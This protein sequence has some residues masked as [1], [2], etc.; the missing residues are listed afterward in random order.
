MRGAMID[1]GVVLGPGQ[2]AESLKKQKDFLMKFV[3][4]YN[5]GR[6]ELLL[7]V[8]K[9]AENPVILAQ[10]HGKFGAKT[11]NHFT[12]TLASYAYNP[13]A[14][15]NLETAINIARENL[16][17]K[18]DGREQAKKVLLIFVDKKV[19]S[20]LAKVKE[21]IEN[22]Q[23]DGVNVI[24]VLIGPAIEK[25]SF[26]DVGAQNI[27]VPG[28]YSLIVLMDKIT[29]AIGTGGVIGTGIYNVIL[30]SY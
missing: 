5:F 17:T 24:V 10:L 18:A 7:E 19:T 22:L 15:S 6:Y 1:L 9:N 16:V 11:K 26:D 20:D 12:D 30:T 8:V 28:P 25:S 29:N 2:S 14:G 21:A 4:N 27:Y 13:D 23:E 3:K